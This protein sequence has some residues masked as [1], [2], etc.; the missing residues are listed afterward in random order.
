[1]SR[2]LELIPTTVKYAVAKYFFTH[3]WIPRRELQAILSSPER[4]ASQAAT[5]FTSDEDE[6]INA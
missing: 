4:A 3:D 2:A 1:M 6:Q 5:L